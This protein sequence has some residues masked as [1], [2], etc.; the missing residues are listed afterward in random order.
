MYS[1]QIICAKGISSG[2]SIDTLDLYSQ[3]TLA[4]HL[5][6]AQATLGRIQ[7]FG[8]NSKSWGK[9]NKGGGKLGGGKLSVRRNRYHSFIS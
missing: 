5:I 6:D 7:N 3:S 2:V 9:L 8:A 4:Q 1:Y